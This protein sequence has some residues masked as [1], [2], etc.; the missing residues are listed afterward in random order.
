[1]NKDYDVCPECLTVLGESLAPDRV[2]CG[3][4]SDRVIS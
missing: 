4:E 3:C 1:M 2:D